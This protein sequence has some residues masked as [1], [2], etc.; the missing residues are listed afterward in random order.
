V[1]KMD[2][3]MDKMRSWYISLRVWLTNLR[4]RLAMGDEEL[5][6][7]LSTIIVAIIHM[8]F[9]IAFFLFALKVSVPIWLRWAFAIYLL[10][11]MVFIFYMMGSRGR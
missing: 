11:Y 5:A 2:S 3:V 10:L 7:T 1:E 8:P 9:L 4:I 6:F